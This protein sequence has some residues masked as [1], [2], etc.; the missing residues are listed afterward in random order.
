MGW[1]L[2]RL[3]EDLG[4]SDEQLGKYLS[5]LRDQ[6]EAQYF[7]NV[8]AMIKDAIDLSRD[9]IVAA[10]QGKPVEDIIAAADQRMARSEA[11][12]TAGQG[13]TNDRLER[14][15][16]AVHGLTSAVVSS[17]RQSDAPIGGELSAMGREMREE[18]MLA[19]TNGRTRVLAR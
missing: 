10:I 8:G 19:L 4:Y 18:R 3:A 9:A 17:D 7:G 16:S 1:T 5:Q 12:R 13:A 2:D 6:F 11:D 14:I 15:E